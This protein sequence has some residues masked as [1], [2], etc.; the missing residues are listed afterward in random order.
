MD[1]DPQN[2]TQSKR[3]VKLTLIVIMLA[4][5]AISTQ[6]THIVSYIA[7]IQRKLVSEITEIDFF[8]QKSRNLMAEV[9]ATKQKTENRLTQLEAELRVSKNSQTAP[10][11]SNESSLHNSKEIILID[12]EQLV[13]SAARH[14]DRPG[15]VKAALNAMKQANKLIQ[16]INKKQ[17]SSLR[18]ALGKDIE[19]LE[20]AT[21]IK[22]M[23]IS[24]QLSKLTNTIDTLPLLANSSLTDVAFIPV[25]ATQKSDNIW[26]KLL[27]ELLQD[28]KELIHVKKTRTPEIKLLPPSQIHFLRENLKLKFMSA[29]FSLISRDETNFRADL[30]TIISWINRYYDKKSESVIKMLRVLNQLHD[31]TFG[32]ALPNVSASLDAIQNYRL[33]INE[34]KL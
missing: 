20:T 34:E 13:I 27:H 19:N 6:W 22:T 14:L 9:Q 10:T 31:K 5:F 30:Q 17:L 18:D 7:N 29:R 25:E 32:I 1:R 2:K 4:A 15:N 28:V 11:I 8:G 33:N 3:F 26:L 21:H 23:E 24:S 12:I 16:N